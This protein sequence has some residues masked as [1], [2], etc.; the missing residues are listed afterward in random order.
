[1]SQ[2]HIEQFYGKALKDPALVNKMLMG[3][4]GPDD[5]IH[6]AVKEGKSQGFDFSYEEADAWIKKQQKIKASGELSDSQLEGVAG[7]KTSTSTSTS[8]SLQGQANANFG[9]AENPNN[10]FGTV[11]TSA[12]TG[13]GQQLG[14]WFTSW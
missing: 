7:G 4:K 6:N 12:W 11:F 5:F 13:V 2:A 9:A 1:M 3:T 8:T 10:S 14:S